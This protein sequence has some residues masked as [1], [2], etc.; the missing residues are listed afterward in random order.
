MSTA[1]P[2][3]FPG[4]GKLLPLGDWFFVGSWNTSGLLLLLSIWYQSLRLQHVRLQHCL[5]SSS[6]YAGATGVRDIAS[7]GTRQL[8]GRVIP[9]S[10]LIED[11]LTRPRVAFPNQSSPEPGLRK[12]ECKLG[13]YLVAKPVGE[14]GCS[15]GM[16][17]SG[18]WAADGS[19]VPDKIFAQP[20]VKG[21]LA[22]KS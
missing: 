20:C 7:C 4:P 21:W 22:S 13:C 15:T 6:W 2:V 18:E 1:V 11:I 19:S 12:R 10:I 5:W 16:D 14:L 3:V 9:P 17:A 8:L